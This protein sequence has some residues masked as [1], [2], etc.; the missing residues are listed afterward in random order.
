MHDGRKTAW[1]IET[2]LINFV[3]GD[4]NLFGVIPRDE[5]CAAANQIHL[6]GECDGFLALATLQ[7][8]LNA[9]FHP[10]K[11]WQIGSRSPHMKLDSPR[12]PCAVFA[13]NLE[14]RPIAVRSDWSEDHLAGIHIR[15]LVANKLPVSFQK[16][17]RASR[18]AHPPGTATTS[19]HK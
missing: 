17:M 8:P 9:A 6:F 7:K 19:P 13:G 4:C 14:V 12:S 18:T 15:Q 5:G 10:D 1:N 3:L 11:R 2:R 16:P